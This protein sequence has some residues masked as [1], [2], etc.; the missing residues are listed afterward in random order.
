MAGRSLA[1]FYSLL[2]FALDTRRSGQKYFHISF[3]L[4]DLCYR[5]LSVSRVPVYDTHVF[6]ELYHIIMMTDNLPGIIVS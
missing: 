2:S 3:T 6:P 4:E 1:V 5:C